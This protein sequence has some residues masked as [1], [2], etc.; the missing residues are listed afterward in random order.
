MSALHDL[1]AHELSAAYRSRKLSPLEVTRAALSRIDAWEKKLTPCTS[2]TR[3]RARD[4][5]CFAG[6]VAPA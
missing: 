6:A 4:G 2:S 3:W 1:S 5:C